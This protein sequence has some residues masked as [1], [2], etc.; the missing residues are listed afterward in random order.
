MI[1]DKEKLQNLTEYKGNCVVV[2]TNN[3]K[4]PIAHVGNTMVSN[5]YSDNDISLQKVYHVPGVYE[6]LSEEGEGEPSKTVE[7]RRSTIIKRPNPKYANATITEEE[8]TTEL[9]TFEEA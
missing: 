3:F 6:Q 2:T 1:G 8:D 7:P 9:K 5:H 4:L